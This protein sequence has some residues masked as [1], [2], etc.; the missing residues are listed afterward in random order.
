MAAPHF[1]FDWISLVLF[2]SILNLVIGSSLILGTTI[3][4]R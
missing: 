2:T 4:T 1:W 3:N